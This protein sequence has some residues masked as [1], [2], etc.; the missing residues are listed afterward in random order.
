[1][2]KAEVVALLGDY[3]RSFSAPVFTGVT[4]TAVRRS[5]AG[6]RV[7]TNEG[8]WL[9]SN[10]VLATGHCDRPSV[11]ASAANLAADIVQVVPSSYHNPGHLPRGGVLVV[12]AS[13][14]GVQLAAEIAGS[15]R[16][17]TL[18]VGRHIR[19]PRRYRG[20][21]ILAWFD[22]LGVLSESA[23]EVRDLAASRRQP[24]LQLVGSDPHRTLDLAVLQEMGVRL[25]GRLTGAE[26]T[27]VWFADDLEAS[28]RHAQ[29]KMEIQLHRVDAH[30]AANRLEAVH[31][32]EGWPA[33]VTAP[34]APSS[35]DLDR[36]GIRSVLWATGYR[37]DYSW[38]QVPVLDAD[39]ELI[40]EGGVTPVPG[41]YA[42]GLNFMRRRNSSFLDG[43][44]ADAAE[45]AAQIARRL[46]RLLAAAS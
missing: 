26:G 41:L 14:T 38:L 32:R 45:L 6:F 8:P 12:G 16:A 20:R 28:L 22:T 27:R 40:H 5:G 37:R 23:R 34:A 1:M 11:P 39:G 24:S 19:L 15:G 25:V 36:E 44:G 35:I 13:A 7:E 9:A 17:V 46:P 31:P 10:V 42:L 29:A 18:A 2:S 30:L 33:P 4:V 43:V 21:D 3:A